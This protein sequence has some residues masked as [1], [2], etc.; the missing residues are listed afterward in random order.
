MMGGME[1]RAAKGIGPKLAEVATWLPPPSRLKEYG[2]ILAISQRAAD[3]HIETLIAET[4][5]E[6]PRWASQTKRF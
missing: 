2:Y 5:K 4:N 3:L 6:D 1:R